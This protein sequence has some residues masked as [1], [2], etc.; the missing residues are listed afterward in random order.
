MVSC[1]F[2]VISD[3]GWAGNPDITGLSDIRLQSFPLIYSTNVPA[4]Q[5]IK[6]YWIRIHGFV[7]KQN[8]F[9]FQSVCIRKPFYLFRLSSRGMGVGWLEYRF[10]LDSCTV[11][12]YVSILRALVIFLNTFI[13]III[14]TF[15][16]GHIYCM[17][18]LY[19]D[20]VLLFLRAQQE[21]LD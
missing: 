17:T 21:F 4:R 16:V 12:L 13:Q 20:R 19:D 14:Y 15:G 8:P 9:D 18:Y 10:S 1:T 11:P 6:T 5:R 7:D 2:S 3:Q